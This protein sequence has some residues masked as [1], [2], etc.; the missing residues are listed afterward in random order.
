MVKKYII[1]SKEDQINLT[2]YDYLVK[3][4]RYYNSRCELLDGPNLDQVK[5]RYIFSVF[6]VHRQFKTSVRMFEKFRGL[7]NPVRITM[8]R[9]K[10]SKCGLYN[11]AFNGLKSWKYV[12]K[13]INLPENLLND[14]RIKGISLAKLN[15]F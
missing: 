9:I 5:E 14:K 15:F 13:S 12:K 10:K 4:R 2:L 3:Y 7:K 6:T 11:Q 1:P 8:N